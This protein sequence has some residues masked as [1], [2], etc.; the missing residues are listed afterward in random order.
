MPEVIQEAFLSI[1]L[2]STVLLILVF[3]YWIMVIFGAMDIS[4]FDFDLPDADADVD[5]DADVGGGG[6]LHSILDFFYIGEVPAMIIISIGVLVFWTVSVLGNYYLNDSRSMLMALPICVGNMVVTIFIT[7]FTM[8]P[9]RAFFVSLNNEEGTIKDVI[10][11]MCIISTTQVSEKMGQAEVA[12][13]QA[14][15]LIN[16]ITEDGSILHKGDH[17]V[18]ISKNTKTGVYTITTTEMEI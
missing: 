10:G 9:F 17:A 18:V 15:I 5:V 8:K 11:Q 12:S 4:L 3:L 16:V 2:I 13:D 1:N 6:F 7:K 14:P